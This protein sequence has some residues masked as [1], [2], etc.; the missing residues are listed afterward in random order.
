MSK[1]DDAYNAASELSTFTERLKHKIVDR[2]PENISDRELQTQTQA[3]LT[4]M[5]ESMHKLEVALCSHF[6]FAAGRCAGCNSTYDEA[7]PGRAKR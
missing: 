2:I 5:Q 1:R 6:A 4:V 7:F 3:L